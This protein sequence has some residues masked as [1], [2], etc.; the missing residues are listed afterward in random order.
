MSQ[1]VGSK[2]SE[3]GV[4]DKMAEKRKRKAE[5]QRV[6]RA[7]QSQEK[8]EEYR[9]A[10]AAHMRSIRSQVQ[11]DRVYGTVDHIDRGENE[12]VDHID[13]VDNEA[14]ERDYGRNCF[15]FKK[16]NRYSL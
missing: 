14:I 9:A 12:T 8:K 6:C 16:L 4:R 15:F 2:V 10:N 7:R 11:I 5:N 13:R 3:S 1:P